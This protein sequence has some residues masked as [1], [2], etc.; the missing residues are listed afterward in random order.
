MLHPNL[1]I[2]AIQRMQRLTKLNMRTFLKPI[3]SLLFF[4]LFAVSCQVID[5]YTGQPKFSKAA[6]GAIIGGV[7]GAAVGALSGD[8]SK[9]RRKRALI[10]GGIGALAGGGIGG[11]MDAQEAKLRRELQSTGVSVTRRGNEIIL[12]MPGNVTFATNSAQISPNFNAVLVS[13]TKVLKEY[14]RTLVDVAGH[15]DNTGDRNYN[16]ELSN[17]RATSVADFLRSQSIDPRRLYVQGYGP[18]HPVADNSTPE[19]RQQN[20]RVELSLQPLTQ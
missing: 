3:A 15:T 4:S 14:D 13:V 12:N 7:G 20:R 8:D 11:Y 10:G 1:S 17:R 16:D 6:M 5:P 18:A 9:E 2:K 19:G